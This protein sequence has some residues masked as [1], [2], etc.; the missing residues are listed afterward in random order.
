[1]ADRQLTVLARLPIVTR[2]C[3]SITMLRLLR[4]LLLVLVVTSTVHRLVQWKLAHHFPVRLRIPGRKMWL[5][6]HRRRHLLRL[7][8]L[9][10]IQRRNTFDH[11]CIRS[12]TRSLYYF[13]L[14]NFAA[15]N[16][17]Q[18]FHFIQLAFSKMQKKFILLTFAK[19]VNCRLT[20]HRHKVHLWI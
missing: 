14:L 20:R 13:I 5:L 17:F 11:T 4:L 12:I 9:Q 19:Y 10:T 8:T 15:R 1:V 6:L 2:R 18:K 3:H 7:V 16:E